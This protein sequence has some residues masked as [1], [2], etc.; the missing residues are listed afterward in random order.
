MRVLDLVDEPR[1][2]AVMPGTPEKDEAG[3]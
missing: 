2:R 1:E 3:A